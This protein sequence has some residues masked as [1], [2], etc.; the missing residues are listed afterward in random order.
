MVLLHVMQRS[1]CHA[2]FGN[3]FCGVTQVAVKDVK[4]RRGIMLLHPGNV[5][6]LGGQ[7]RAGKT[8]AGDL[9]CSAVA[10]AHPGSAG[11]RVFAFA[12]LA[13]QALRPLGMLGRK[14]CGYPAGGS[15]GGGEEAGAGPVVA[16][17]R[18]VLRGACGALGSAMHGKPRCLC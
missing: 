12:H 18:H 8:A 1:E 7:V 16:A 4:V 5:A 2:A 9:L 6:I 15:S 11:F 17:C 10:F 14:W 3:T 13:Q